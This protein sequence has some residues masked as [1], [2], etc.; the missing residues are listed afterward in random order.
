MIRKREDY[1]ITATLVNLMR[2]TPGTSSVFSATQKGNKKKYLKL[3]RCL[4]L[5]LRIRSSHLEILGDAC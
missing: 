1:H 4:L 5:L 3:G 2:A